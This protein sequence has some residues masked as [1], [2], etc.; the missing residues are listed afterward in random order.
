VAFITSLRLIIF[1]LVLLLFE[2][3]VLE[4]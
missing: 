1:E 4:V 3:V 2:R